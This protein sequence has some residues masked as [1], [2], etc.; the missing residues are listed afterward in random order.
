MA[1]LPFTEALLSIRNTFACAWVTGC[2]PFMTQ[3]SA[4]HLPWTAGQYNP[5]Q[6]S[7]ADRMDDILSRTRNFDVL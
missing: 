7:S 1:P 4:M 5:L 2:W 6:A 3:V